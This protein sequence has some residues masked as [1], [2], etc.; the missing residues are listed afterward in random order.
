MFKVYNMTVDDLNSIKNILNSD[1][2]DFW[3]Y[4]I[5]NSELNNNSSKYIIIKNENNQIVGFGGIKII[6]DEAD[7]M[8][9]VT[10]K[11][12]RNIG[13]GSII[14]Q[15]LINI[16]KSENLKSITLEVAENNLPAINLY[17]KFM[18]EIVGIRNKYYNNEINA[19]LM[20]KKL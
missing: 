13:I 17:K 8:N 9:I 7:I 12:C 14:L 16:S 19:I 3:D 15:N 18:F 2:D 4:N 6:I 1:F 20:T 11:S 5:L 10:K